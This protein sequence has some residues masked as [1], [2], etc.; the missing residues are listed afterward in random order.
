MSVDCRGTNMSAVPTNVSQLDSI[1]Q[2]LMKKGITL[3]EDEMKQANVELQNV[4]GLKR[5]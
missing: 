2:E 1:L 5:K 3:Q 4:S